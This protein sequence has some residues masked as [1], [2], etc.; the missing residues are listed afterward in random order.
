MSEVRN[1]VSVD[2]HLQPLSG[3]ALCYQTDNSDPNAWLD[4]ANGFWGGR[5]ECSFLMLG[6]STLVLNQIVHL[7]RSA[8][9]QY[10]K[11]K[12]HQYEQ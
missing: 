3:E 8:Y 1:N 5:F 11:D 12:R 10:E 7:H 6:F 4:I 9:C 2:S